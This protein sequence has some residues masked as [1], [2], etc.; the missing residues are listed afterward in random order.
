MKKN[1]L[2]MLML[3]LVQIVSAANAVPPTRIN[4]IFYNLDAN[5]KQ[6]EVTYDWDDISIPNRKTYKGTITIPATVSYQGITYAVTSIDNTAF[7]YNTELKAVNLPNSIL[8]IGWNA[9][10][11]CKNL[12]SL[13]IPKSVT[14]ID[15]GILSY[16]DAITSIT[17]DKEN[18]VYD[19]RNN[20]N[21]IIHTATNELIQG[22]QNTI[23]PNT[24]TRIGDDA[25]LGIRTLT[26]IDIPNSVSNIGDDAFYE[27]GIKEIVLPNS[28]VYLGWGA[29]KKCEDLTNVTLSESLENIPFDAFGECN[30]KSVIIPASVVSI[31]NGVFDNFSSNVSIYFQSTTPPYI[32]DNAFEQKFWG[33]NF[34]TIHVPIGY[35]DAYKNNDA[36]KY[37]TIIDDVVVPESAT[38]ISTLTPVQTQNENIF[39]LSGERLHAPRKGINIINGKK[40]NIK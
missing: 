3:M 34:A 37:F 11:Y 32:E 5:K 15:L 22:C 1:F 6:A 26:S 31:E 2:V 17:V 13:I 27:T 21:A 16:C 18:N 19:S 10:F 28:V 23:I 25:F 20:C 8:H 29:F 38:G 35:K 30:I 24:I 40:I 7:S 14:D 33:W 36:W 4:G 12:K 39:T 9:F